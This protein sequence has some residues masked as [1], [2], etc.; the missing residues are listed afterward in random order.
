MPIL[1]RQELSH[2]ALLTASLDGTLTPDA[3]RTI[4]KLYEALSLPTSALYSDLHAMQTGV[5]A[6]TLVRPGGNAS[7]GF[8][9][10]QRPSDAP[11][12]TFTLDLD[13]VRAKLAD[14]HR[15][16]ALL[17][18]VF[19]DEEETEAASPIAEPDALPGLDA[20][21]SALTLVLVEQAEWSRD[22]FEA[23][24]SERG[25]MSGGALE[26]INEWAFD[27]L[28]DALIE[29]DDPLTVDLDAWRAYQSAA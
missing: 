11:A 4:S 12:P 7:L 9:L 19:A 3:S 28:G 10:P 13:A 16:S 5:D 24:A 27:A 14:T 26:A 17:A 18:D 20:P 29:D 25:L 21:H 8:A 2:H 6:P 22:T 1:T 23:L 15:A